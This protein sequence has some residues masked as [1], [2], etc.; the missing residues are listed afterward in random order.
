VWLV[1]HTM[2]RKNARAPAPFT[3]LISFHAFSNRA[4]VVRHPTLLQCRP[5]VLT[6]AQ[7]SLTLLVALL[8]TSAMIKST[9]PS[10]VGSNNNIVRP[11]LVQAAL[12]QQGALYYFG[13]GSNML[14]SKVENRGINGSKIE[15]ISMEPC[16]VENHRL[17]FNVRGFPP[18]EPAMA[19][20]ESTTEHES[21]SAPLLSF[22]RAECH[23]A[24]IRLNASNYDNLMRS[25][26]VHGN[27]T[28]PGYEEVVVTAIPYD[29]SKPPVQAISLRA[30]PHVRL[31]RDGYPSMRYM[32]LLRD[33]A[34][35]LGL[36]PDYRAF[37]EAHPTHRTPSFLKWMSLYNIYF[38][39]SIARLLRGWRGLN[40]LQ[41]SFLYCV[42]VP[43]SAPAF[44]RVAGDLGTAA[45]LMPG[46]CC[47]VLILA[48]RR[49][50]T[51]NEAPMMKRLRSMLALS[52]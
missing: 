33:G 41:S 44:Q 31:S 34:N 43:A 45:I 30:R 50:V 37:L 28:S 11:P 49:I 29:R 52:K 40:R 17:A 32:T 42:H 2:D 21:G 1:L 46:F 3:P 9:S 5:L 20:L 16:Y 26:G 18:L 6:M 10:T 23:G 35:E 24:L 47:G 19:S 14:R 25:E 7:P 36:T 8:S 51:R 38:M 39:S 12:E 13:L 22:H 4:V 48:A 27:A 15:F